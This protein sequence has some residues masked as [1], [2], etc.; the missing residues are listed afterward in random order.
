MF[1]RIWQPTDPDF[2]LEQTVSDPR[3]YESKADTNALD[4]TDGLI[5]T[6]MN[7]FQQR[8][9]PRAYGI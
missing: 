6:T 9:E 8:H 7:T 4:M 1:G 2:E 3:P 5:R